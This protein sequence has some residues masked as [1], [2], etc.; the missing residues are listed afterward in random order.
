MFGLQISGVGLG[1]TRKIIEIKISS[2]QVFSFNISNY[3]TLDSFQMW[4][5]EYIQLCMPKPEKPQL[6]AQNQV[7]GGSSFYLWFSLL[8]M[9]FP[10]SVQAGQP[11]TQTNKLSGQIKRVFS[12]RVP[13]LC[14][15]V[16]CMMMFRWTNKQPGIQK[17]WNLCGHY[18][19][20]YDWIS[21]LGLSPLNK[22]SGLPF[23][24]TQQ[25]MGKMGIKDW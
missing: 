14:L 4:A 7:L 13:A 25:S 2:L 3:C 18:Q 22:W 15:W 19:D 20:I 10:V 24:L 1:R 5:C 23:I 11:D 12:L 8:F 21:P 16:C 9:F 6:F 17:F